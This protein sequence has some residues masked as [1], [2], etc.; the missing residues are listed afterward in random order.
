MDKTLRQTLTLLAIV[1][2]I[3][4]SF[5]YEQVAYKHIIGR[6]IDSEVVRLSFI[7]AFAFNASKFILAWDIA[8]QWS[9]GD[10]FLVRHYCAFGLLVLNSIICSQMVV[11]AQLDAPNME[12]AVYAKKAELKE[13]FALQDKLLAQR[14]TTQLQTLQAQYRQ[15]REL[16]INLHQPMIER[17]QKT[18]DEEKQHTY[19]DGTFDGPRYQEAERQLL[20]EKALLDNK[21]A[22]L[23]GQEKQD[24]THLRQQLDTQMAESTASQLLAFEQIK[25][26][27]LKASGSYLIEDELVSGLIRIVNGALGWQVSSVFLIFVLALLMSL[28]IEVVSFAMIA[29]LH[30]SQHLDTRAPIPLPMNSASGDNVSPLTSVSRQ[31]SGL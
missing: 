8:R 3:F 21:I 19:Q 7:V 24:I 20:N 18:M 5:Y 10:Y 14:Y 9:Q 13:Q 16:A 29:S 22:A 4:C 26:E 12:Q 30:A 31:T 17:Y 2:L 11:S 15:N 28:I 27:N 23:N 6:L 25:K 1:G